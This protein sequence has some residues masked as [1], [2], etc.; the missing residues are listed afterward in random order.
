MKK[1]NMSHVL[2]DV[3]TGPILLV[4]FGIPALIII[5][6]IGLIVLAVFLIR[7]RRK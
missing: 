4:M 7:K 2:F 3:A 1:R 5:G 6:V